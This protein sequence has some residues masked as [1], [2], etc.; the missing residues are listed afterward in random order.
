MS[1]CA[2][3]SCGVS[4]D[5]VWEVRG[6]CAGTAAA[7]L[8]QVI[9]ANTMAAANAVARLILAPSLVSPTKDL[10][11]NDGKKFVGEWDLSEGRSGVLSAVSN[12]TMRVSF[13]VRL[14]VVATIMAIVAG[15]TS[16]FQCVNM[17]AYGTGWEVAKLETE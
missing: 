9:P 7:P 10:D 8:T 15:P 16:A 3:R 14:E 17:L 1:R 13:L 12:I 5:A 4:L 6:D 2:M 11:E